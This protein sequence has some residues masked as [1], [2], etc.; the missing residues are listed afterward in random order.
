MKRLIYLILVFSGVL[1]VPVAAEEALPT[2][3]QILERYV[4][5]LGGREA[6]AAL[7][8]R[9][10]SG[11]EIDD[12]PNQGPPVESALQ[13]WADDGGD[14]T[15][16]LKKDSGQS[17]EGSAGGKSWVKKPGEDTAEAEYK[18]TK[19]AFLFNP[20]GPLMVEKHF[21]NLHMT[22]TWDY[23]G[24]QYY[25]VENDLKFEYYTLYFE[26]ETGLLTRIGYHWKIEGYR[27]VDGVLVPAKVAQG[28]KGGT[29]DL[30]FDEVTHNVEV[31]EHL[32]P[33]GK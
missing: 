30:Y 24:V 25:K 3:D 17:R 2:L 33:G 8:S 13:V 5:A 31:A 18:N 26:V 21:P 4:D 6:I 28:R 32:Q 20:Q 12:R 19:L 11:R 22:G 29:T 14:W 15:M 1:T 23:D 16:S 27:P 10:I 9:V 7:E